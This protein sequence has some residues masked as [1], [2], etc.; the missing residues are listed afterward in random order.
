MV[1]IKI[2]E[3]GS[4]N[5]KYQKLSGTVIGGEQEDLLIGKD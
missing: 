5:F 4:S 1:G 2:T 3:K